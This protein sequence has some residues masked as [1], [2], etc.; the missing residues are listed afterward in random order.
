MPT[1]S[2]Q[3]KN[4]IVS[5]IN[6]KDKFNKILD[7]GCGEG[8]YPTL[9][10]KKCNTVKNTEWWGIEAWKN[11]IDQFNLK[12]KYNHIINEDVR[13]V[14]WNKMPDF[15]LIIFGDILEHMTKQ[16]S[17]TVISHALKKTKYVLIS[18]PIIFS[19]Q[20]EYEGNPFEIHVKPD[21]SHDEVLN[22]FPNII[23]SWKGSKIGVYILKNV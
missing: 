5:W 2:K 9:L 19:P 15:D 17:Q 10:K 4:E 18:I 6:S 13:K 14:D 3:G 22:S 1:S 21:W 16:E 8:T 23:Y 11:Y 20:G 7:V 12:S